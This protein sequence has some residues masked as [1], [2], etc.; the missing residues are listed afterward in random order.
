MNPHVSSAGT[1]QTWRVLPD[2]RGATIRWLDPA[3]FELARSER[4]GD[5]RG[6]WNLRYDYRLDLADA[7]VHA[8]RYI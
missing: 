2:L 5:W 6:D 3:G 8:S 7:E 1:D 4:P